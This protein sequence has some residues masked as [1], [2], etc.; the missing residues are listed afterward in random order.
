MGWWTIYIDDDT[1]QRTRAAAGAAGMSVSR[2][3]TEVLRA[4]LAAWPADVAELA[5]SWRSPDEGVAGGA[6][7]ASGRGDDV[8]REPL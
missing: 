5:G 6:A 7:G 2:W 1:E 8:T 3:I 4:R